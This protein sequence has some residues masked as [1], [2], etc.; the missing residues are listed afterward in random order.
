[1]TRMYFLRCAVRA[2][3]RLFLETDVVCCLAVICAIAKDVVTVTVVRDRFFSFFLKRS[4]L[5]FV[6]RRGTD[7]T[8]GGEGSDQTGG[9]L[10]RRKGSISDMPYRGMMSEN[11]LRIYIHPPSI[12]VKRQAREYIDYIQPSI[13]QLERMQRGKRKSYSCTSE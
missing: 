3:A 10:G 8:C 2:Y 12:T 5:P 11:K 6:A 13:P 1:M 7:G 4:A 9:V